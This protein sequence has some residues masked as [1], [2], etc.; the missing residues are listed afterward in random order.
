MTDTTVRLLPIEGTYNLREVGG[1]RAGHT[2]VRSGKLYRSD[3]LNGLTESGRHALADLGIRRIVDLRTEEEV[4]AGPTRLDADV[5]IVHAPIFTASHRPVELAGDDVTLAAVYDVMVDGHGRQLTDA[6]RLIASA[7]DGAVLVHCTAGKDRTGLVVALALL[8]AGV[9]REEVVADY[10]Q[11]SANL[12]GEWA[13]RM[14]DTMRGAGGPV[15]PAMQEI[16]TA[17]PASE[18]TR[19]ISRWDSE[20]G[21][22]A[23]YLRAHGITDEELTALSAMLLV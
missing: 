5:E 3:A 13:A 7:G 11:T 1:Y 10:A 16:V 9:D 15:S 6:V 12:S 17:S 22:P 19:V 21:S 18:L 23:D 20:W 14:L 4:T 8:A 2:T